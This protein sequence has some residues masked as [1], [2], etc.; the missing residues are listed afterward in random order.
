MKK[1]PYCAEEIQDEAIICKHCKQ[2]LRKP[3]SLP[4]ISSAPAAPPVKQTI[5]V[6]PD[7]KSPAVGLVG[8][9]TIIA[10]VVVCAMGGGNYAP[11]AIVFIVGAC[12]LGYA[13][14]TG[15][16]TLFG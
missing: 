12:I 7:R 1:C 15:K 8:I 3:D 9:L 4:P 14:L 10:G 5:V 2:D 11:G 6:E 16:I 13:M